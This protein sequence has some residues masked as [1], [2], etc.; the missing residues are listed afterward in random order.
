[1]KAWIKHVEGH[2]FLAKSESNHWIPFD[3]ASHGTG[4]AGD[5]YQTFAM[6]CGGCASIDV[7]DILTKSRKPPTKLE[8][9]LEITRADSIPKIAR[10]LHYH[11][12]VEGHDLTVER[13][14]RAIELSLTTY[15]SV[16]LSLDRSV[17]FSAQIT[18]N[19][20]ENPPWNIRRS[21]EIYR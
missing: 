6:A 2:T 17:N 15:C 18:L 10:R 19:G 12:R 13:I 9:E 8:L 5:P 20:I 14:Q 1:M 7:V 11:F 16:A 3:T 4:A 21:D